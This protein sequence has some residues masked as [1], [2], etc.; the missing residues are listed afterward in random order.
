MC[1]SILAVAEGLGRE[2]G[3]DPRQNGEDSVPEGGVGE[4]D[5]DP[6][7]GEAVA[8]GVLV[9][10]PR[11]EGGEEHGGGDA[12]QDPA[13]HEDAEAG[14]ELGEAAEGVDDAE[15]KGNLLPTDDV[16]QRSGRGAEHEARGETGHVE[17][18]DLKAEFAV[19]AETREISP[20]R[21]KYHMADYA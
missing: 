4:G 20:M 16:G 5:A 11:L 3:Y 6:L 10:V 7:G 9:D 18:G 1:R 14:A 17:D 21:M 19:T 12:A 2:V 15:G 8:L 13:Q